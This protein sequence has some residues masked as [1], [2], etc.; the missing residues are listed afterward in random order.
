M[1]SGGPQR[2]KTGS[3]PD[4]ATG[5]RPRLRSGGTGRLAPRAVDS[6]AGRAYSKI[7]LETE[8]HYGL[9][10]RTSRVMRPFPSCYP[11]IRRLGA[12][13]I[14]F[15]LAKGLVWLGLGLLVKHWLAGP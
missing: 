5:P 3:Y 11:W 13:G 7:N 9:T 4:A 2:V 15:F 14:L 10:P 8:S 12:I 1:L 6:G